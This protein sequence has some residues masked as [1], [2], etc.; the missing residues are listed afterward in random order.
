MPHPLQS[1][2]RET[3]IRRATCLG[4]GTWQ[5]DS[6]E[7]VRFPARRG[8]VLL[9]LRWLD[10]RPE[11]P[12]PLVCGRQAEAKATGFS[13]IL[14]KREELLRSGHGPGGIPAKPCD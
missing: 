3:T 11:G 10:S 8:S 6:R 9:G 7:D 1:F 14:V 5:R 4:T 2:C 13:S 12:G